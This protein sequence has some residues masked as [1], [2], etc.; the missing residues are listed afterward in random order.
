MPQQPTRV[1]YISE[2]PM[3]L[4]LRAIRETDRLLSKRSLRAVESSSRL[5]QNSLFYV[6]H[7]LLGVQ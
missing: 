1:V 7:L 2:S 5:Y 4:N 6:R 3:A